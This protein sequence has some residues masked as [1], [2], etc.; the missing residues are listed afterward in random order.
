MKRTASILMAISAL[1]GP[2]ACGQEAS[3]RAQQ[4]ADANLQCTDQRFLEIIRGQQDNYIRELTR[5]ES[6][7]RDI[8]ERHQRWLEKATTPE[9][10]QAWGD[11]IEAYQKHCKSKKEYHQG[12]HETLRAI[13]TECYPAGLPLLDRKTI[14][15]Q[16]AAGG[17]AVPPIVDAKVV[18]A[19]ALGDVMP[20]AVPDGETGGRLPERSTPG[21]SSVRGMPRN[22][23]TA[24]SPSCT[25]LSSLKRGS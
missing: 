2:W 10:P 23:P 7:E 4:G 15:D 13:L 18:D 21:L 17:E 9:A 24:G 16:H 5:S 25:I 12:V 8:R 11:Y 19:G 3:L 1:S 20:R 22:A 6:A 14:A